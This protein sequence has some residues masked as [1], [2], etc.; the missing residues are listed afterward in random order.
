VT[1]I[2]AVTALGIRPVAGPAMDYFPKNRLLSSAIGA[3]ALSFIVYGFAHSITM[4]IVSRLIHGIGM[5]LSAPLSL[6][7]VSN[8]VP[9][10]K[11]ASGLGMFSLGSAV[12]T[13]VGPTVG[14]KLSAVIGYN[15]VF[16]ISAALMASCFVL[17]LQLKDELYIKG[18]RFRIAL[19]QVIAPEAIL[20]TLVIFLQML[21]FSSIN[22]FIAI[23][24]GLKGVGDI[25][26]YFTANAV[27]LI[28]IRPLSGRIAD[29]YGLDKTVIPGLVIFM[30]ALI[31]VSF[32]N[33]LLVFMLA[34]A[35]TALGFGISEPILQTLNM[36]LVP[37]ERRGAAGNTN[38]MGIDVGLLIGPT[39]AGFVVSTVQDATGSEA[40]G[41]ETMYRVMIVPVIAALVLFLANR[42]KLL[43]RIKALQDADEATAVQD[44]AEEI[45]AA[46]R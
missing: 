45:G 17:S 8:I 3:I 26:L 36:Q 21:S 41:F 30:G 34:G 33:S 18:E 35:V 25:G 5:G 1:G 10:D 37:K 32:C 11:M 2:F 44:A 24:G 46:G 7:M 16:L 20:P 6:A 42:K 19:N 9:R 27:C 28:F 12:A 15:N 43:R 29:K 38:F 13:A 39:L 31:L 22:S 40:L 23:F 4:I 14:L